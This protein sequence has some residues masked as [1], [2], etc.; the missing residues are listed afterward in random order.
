MEIVAR[1]KR[2]LVKFAGPAII[3]LLIV[4]AF[5]AGPAEAIILHPGGVPDPTYPTGLDPNVVGRWDGSA[6]CVAIAPNYL[7]TT[8]HQSGDTTTPVIIDGITYQIDSIFYEP[9]LTDLR[10]IKLHSANLE[11][12]VLPYS[13]TDELG[14]NCVIIGYGDGW[15]YELTKNGKVYGYLWDNSAN[16]TRRTGTNIIDDD[17]YIVYSGTN[18]VYSS[19]SL[20]ADFDGLGEG[21]ATTYEA[22]IADHDSGGGWFLE[23]GGQWYVCGLN[24]GVSRKDE[25]HFRN[26]TFPQWPSPDIIYAVRLSNHADW[27]ES[28][29]VRCD[30]TYK[31]DYN[32]DCAVDIIDL[33]EFASNWLRQD[34]GP[35]NN[36]CQGSDID[37][38]DGKV[39]LQDLSYFCYEWHNYL[40][41]QQV[42][43][44]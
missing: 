41:S 28:V 2:R 9:N 13:Q 4:S 19:I 26:A 14:K 30:H 43:S 37:P 39:D 35:A 33:A 7:I 38:K 12:Y 18:G 16:T 6:S 29:V 8:R 21:A 44:Y 3:V 36:Y 24:L 31:C 34:C 25:S 15:D 32:G 23:L 11:N 5:W 20:T 27:I 10:V 42:A 22:A 1:V 40:T 17:N